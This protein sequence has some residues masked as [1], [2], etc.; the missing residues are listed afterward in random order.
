[1]KIKIV[2]NSFPSASE[3]FLFNLVAGLEKIGHTVIVCAMSKNNDSKLYVQR[4]DEWSGNINYF[5]S[6]TNLIVASFTVLGI[7]VVMPGKCIHYIRK[8]GIKRG[9]LDSIKGRFLLEGHP[10]IIHFAYSGLGISFLDLF[11][12]LHDKSIKIFVSC[13]GS[14]EKVKPIIDYNRGKQL[15]VLF[16]KSDRVHCVSIDM[17]QG[18]SEYGL[19]KERAFVNYPSIDLEAFVQDKPKN[20]IKNEKWELTT[21]GRLHFQKGYI[22]CLQALRLL[23]N[24]GY[25]FTYHILGS[26]PDLAQLKYLVH[27]WTLDD[28]V[29]FHGKVGSE[30]IFEILKMTDIFI[31]PSLYEGVANS[32]LEAMA[33]KIP[34]VTT[35]AGG[36]GEVVRHRENGMIINRFSGNELAMAIE[37]LLLSGELRQRVSEN[38]RRTVEE[39]FNIHNQIKIFLKE[40]RESL[41]VNEEDHFTFQSG[42]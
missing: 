26:G 4:L 40:Y 19:A 17:L 33:M 20:F 37:E 36:M 2:V 18:L 21:T 39:K 7:I 8:H 5:P 23:K 11:D 16:Q 1:M 12:M 3:T 32:A 27:E 15:G 22:F 28:E 38:G 30:T 29:V 10:D 41:Q 35:N 6:L 34:I 9:L 24:K 13:R 14:A 25:Q 31:L 42:F